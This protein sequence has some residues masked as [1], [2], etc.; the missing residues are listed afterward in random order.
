MSHRHNEFIV[1]T[2]DGL[3]M[4]LDGHLVERSM[5]ACV[6]SSES[7]ARRTARENNIK[8]PW[9]IEQFG[10]ADEQEDC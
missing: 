6:F 9:T 2:A 5:D 3:Y 7:L 4:T 8:G 1:V 10:Y